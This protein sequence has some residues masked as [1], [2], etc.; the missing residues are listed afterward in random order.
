MKKVTL[1]VTLLLFTSCAQQ[2]NIPTQPIQNTTSH[3]KYGIPSKLGEHS[4]HA[5]IINYR[6]VCS[7]T[8]L[9]K[10]WILT[11]R[12]CL[13]YAD[14]ANLIIRV[15]SSNAHKGG[16]VV[17]AKSLISSDNLTL[18]ELASDLK[19]NKNVTIAALPTKNIEAKGVSAGQSII[20][21]GWDGKKDSFLSKIILNIMTDDECYRYAWPWWSGI[22]GRNKSIDQKNYSS[23]GSSLTKKIKGQFYILG[24]KT[25]WHNEFLFFRITNEQSWITQQTGIQP[26]DNHKSDHQVYEEVI[27][28]NESQYQPRSQGFKHEGG[29]LKAD[30]SSNS[31]GYH[32]FDLYLQKYNGINWTP[33]RSSAKE[34]N[35]TES[36]QES[37]TY[38]APPGMYRWEVYSYEGNGKYKLATSKR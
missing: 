16:Q 24:I 26:K 15:G 21:L 33:V 3:I 17:K 2:R 18:I 14:A 36:N 30:L 9:A 20:F 12:T 8:I 22:C 10:N 35:L 11:S 38:H 31:N 25:R 4:Y 13:F 37:I 29:T 19:L 34:G 28:T 6:S 32:D 7:G 5:A 23:E 1:C 27:K